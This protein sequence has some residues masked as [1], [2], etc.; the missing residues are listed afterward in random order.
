M[1]ERQL[2]ST[3]F[4]SFEKPVDEDKVDNKNQDTGDGESQARPVMPVTEYAE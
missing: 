2:T 4:M 1:A 3:R